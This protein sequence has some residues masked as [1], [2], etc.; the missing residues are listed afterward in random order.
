LPKDVL[1]VIKDFVF[2][3]DPIYFQTKKF[4][5][6]M[7]R[8][9]RQ[10][11]VWL[12]PEDPIWCDEDDITYASRMIQFDTLSHICL[13]CGNYLCS[14]NFCYAL[15]PKPIHCLCSHHSPRICIH[16][17]LVVIN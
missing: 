15:H 1:R 9:I 12:E 5:L 16:F 3:D 6:R 2:I 10:Q 7:F 4:Q 14:P 11:G 8:E 17:P 13:H